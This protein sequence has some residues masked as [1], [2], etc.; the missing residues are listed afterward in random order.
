VPVV[1]D[2]KLL[3]VCTIHDTWS[4]IP[5]EDGMKAGLAPVSDSRLREFYLASVC[6]IIAFILGVVCPLT[7]VFGYYT[8]SASSV[9]K[10][11]PNANSLPGSIT[12]Y[13]FLAHGAGANFFADYFTL[14]FTG[15]AVW[16]LILILGFANLA[17]AVIGLF[18]VIYTS[19]ATLH[20]LHTERFHHR[21]FPL[22]AA[23]FI[24]LEWI[25]LA[26]TLS[27]VEPQAIFNVDP[28]G[29]TCSIIAI[30]LIILAI[31]REQVF[32][33]NIGGK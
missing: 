11:F 30:G 14:V 29:L 13:M 8:A 27:A 9:L 32:V 26:I 24:A 10:L 5:P 15:G 28:V 20:G 22:A 19:Y 6:A 12:F 7:G 3:G 33:Q 18:S 31:F 16:D 21:A 17:C 2:G 4:Y 1:E 23:L 25:F